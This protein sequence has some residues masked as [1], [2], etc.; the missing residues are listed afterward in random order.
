MIVQM[1]AT[2]QYFLAVLFFAFNIMVLASES[3]NEMV[4]CL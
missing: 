4:K 3:E 1:R 2:E